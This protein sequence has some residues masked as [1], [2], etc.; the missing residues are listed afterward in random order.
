[1]LA[2]VGVA[3]LAVWGSW[4]VGG[5]KRGELKR[6]PGQWFYRYHFLGLDF[7]HNYH[8]TRHWLGGG[9]PYREPFGD[10]LDRKLCYPPI[11]LPFFSWCQACSPGTA[12]VVWTAALA[13]LAGLGAFASW[14]VRHKLGLSPVPLPFALAVVLASTPVTY[15]LERGN[16]DLLIVPLLLGAAWA[17]QKQSIGRDAFAGSCLALATC[18]KVY[19]ALLIVALLP[20]RRARAALLAVLA[21]GLFG[22]FQWE[23]LPV[24]VENLRELARENN[25]ER[26]GVL[27]TAGH[28][29]TG[30][31]KLVWE[32][33]RC[34][35]LAQ[36]PPLLAALV[37]FGPVLA[38]LADRTYRCA[39]PGPL[40]LPLLLWVA[41]VATFIPSVANDYNLVFLPMAAL[42]VWDRR[43]PVPAH[44]GMA[45]LLVWAQPV[46]FQIDL[47][48]LLV[49]KVLSTLAV[50]VC[51]AGRLR[52]ATTFAQFPGGESVCPAK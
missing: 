4:W 21:V 11:V 12:V 43:D 26:V 50:G 5:L 28:S 1:M 8:A 13:G 10:P 22:A 25:S 41:S 32:G 7:L 31:W 37:V 16:Y 9:D 46:A 15:A 52:E 27:S 44:L 14:R 48:V 36:V 49:L 29:L 23:S 17:L 24:C 20:L 34:A 30:G 18:F 45:A 51:L 39:D 6:S 40:V 47:A 2:I 19:P 38:W 42:A 3:I 33:T 35:G